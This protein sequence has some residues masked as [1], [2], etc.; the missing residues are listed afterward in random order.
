MKYLKF[1]LL[2]LTLLLFY[3][4]T[5]YGIYYSLLGFVFLYSLSWIWLILGFSI[6]FGLLTIVISEIPSLLRIL[7]FKMYNY[8]KGVVILHTIA[9]FI[10][11]I[12]IL[13]FF[14]LNPIGNSAENSS[15]LGFMWNQA[16]FK[17]IV[18][19]AA[20]ISF[21]ISFLISSLYLPIYGDII[22]EEN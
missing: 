1:L 7:I 9:G 6:I 2:P 14:Y 16:P 13:Y 11:L 3:C 12:A 8:N 19:C 20:Y 10:G 22:L 17:T 15:F 5:Y 21:I 18:I 4:F